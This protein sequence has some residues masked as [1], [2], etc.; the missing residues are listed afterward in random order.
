MLEAK[1]SS[2]C[3]ATVRYAPWMARRTA[4]KVDTCKLGCQL[5]VSKTQRASD[6]SASLS[7]GRKLKILALA[8]FFCWHLT[9]APSGPSTF[10]LPNTCCVGRQ[11][12]HSAHSLA[13]IAHAIQDELRK[14]SSCP[15]A[16]T[17][18]T[19]TRARTTP[20]EVPEH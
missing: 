20:A 17:A 4:T 2:P 15:S 19:R 10:A 12:L 11:H 5:Q 18:C 13:S 8:F 14:R 3:E 16:D 7:C 9:D 6:G 1:P